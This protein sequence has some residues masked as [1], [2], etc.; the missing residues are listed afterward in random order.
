[1]PK[2]WDIA[3]KNLKSIYRD[4]K[5]WL[6]ILLIPIFYYSLMGAIFGGRIGN[7]TYVY[8]IGYVN[9]DES[10]TI[11]NQANY[12]LSEIYSIIEDA[13]AFHMRYYTDNNSAIHD[14]EEE[15]VD[16]VVVFQEGFQEYLNSSSHKKYAIFDNDTSVAHISNY[17]HQVNYFINVTSSYMDITN[18]SDFYAFIS[19]FNDPNFPID[20]VI[21]FQEGF[22]ANLDAT[23]NASFTFYYRD[24]TSETTVD[25]QNMI[26]QG[27]IES[28]MLQGHLP[29]ESSSIES[30][31]SLIESSVP[32]YQ[33]DVQ[34]YFRDSTDITSKQ[35]IKGMMM[36][37][38]DGIINYNP[39]SIDLSYEDVPI[40]G[41]SVSWLTT[42]TPGYI[43]YGMLSLLS[44]ATI[45]ITNEKK[46]GT[47]KR[48]ES[49]RMRPFDM[50]FGH[51]V[52]NTA[53]VI[54]QFLIGIGVLAIFGFRP[55]Y[56]SVWSLIFGTLITLLLASIFINALSL[57]A[58]VIFKTP[59]AS[60][61]GVW[62][63]LIPLMTFSGAFFPL[64]VIAPGLVPYTTWIPTRIVVLLFQ[65][66]FVDG[67]GL[68]D[69]S[70]WL[71]FLWLTLWGAGLFTL[72]AFLYRRFA[73]S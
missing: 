44:M 28:I 20:Y 29:S 49:S 18:I 72:G 34:F 40:S 58:A 33:P 4:K 71:N 66:I 60:G 3:I 73:Q 21:V 35:I 23:L 52:S 19:N 17:T 68:L 38:L 25:I 70:I 6:F 50:L 30:T 63:F 13:E 27:T 62:V 12:N 14:L 67:I 59:E 26:I 65:D 1:M 56:A 8:T 15:E 64:E 32:K 39:S 24:T 47:L 7:D 61:G 53:I 36:A 9:M 37:F 69:P 10:S 48:L 5:S 16:A 55:I 2:F 46:T 41:Q 42:G 51:I 22:E 45:L 54:T 57:V 11:I 31:T 43:M